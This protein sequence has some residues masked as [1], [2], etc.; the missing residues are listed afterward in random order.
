MENKEKENNQMESSLSEDRREFTRVSLH[1]RAEIEFEDQ[2]KICGESFDLSL[3]GLSIEGGDPSLVGKKCKATIVL[4]APPEDLRLETS[5]IVDQHIQGRLVVTFSGIEVESFDH[6]RN[7]V[8]YNAADRQK[9]E[10][11]FQQHIGLKKTTQ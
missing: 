2:T 4:N 5:G 9:V 11:E 7:L 3:K 8:L 1:I 10:M 6:L